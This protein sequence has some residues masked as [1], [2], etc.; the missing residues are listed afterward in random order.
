MQCLCRRPHSNLDRGHALTI[1]Y[2]IWITPQPHG[3][4]LACAHQLGRLHTGSVLYG[5]GLEDTTYVGL[6]CRLL[7]SDW[8]QGPIPNLRATPSSLLYLL[9]NSNIHKLTPTPTLSQAS[10]MRKSRAWQIETSIQPVSQ[11]AQSGRLLRLPAK[12]FYCE[13]THWQQ[14]PRWG[15]ILKKQKLVELTLVN[16]KSDSHC[17]IRFVQLIH[18]ALY[19]W[20][21]WQVSRVEINLKKWKVW[22]SQNLKINWYSGGIL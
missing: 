4:L 13:H 8:P 3:S 19:K 9:I 2:I 1:W 20:V 18:A 17:H 10:S 21:R 11:H 12:R 6:Q 5:N 22:K 15:Y 16:L 14:M 7:N